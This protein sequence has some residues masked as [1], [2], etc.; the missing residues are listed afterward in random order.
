MQPH[1]L[2]HSVLMGEQG[3][4]NR[5][6]TPAWGIVQA[7]NIVRELT[8]ERNEAEDQIFT[9]RNRAISGTLDLRHRS[10]KVAVDIQDCQF[11]GEVDVRNC[12]FEQSVDLSRCTFHHAFNSGDASGASTVYKKDLVCSEATFEEEASFRGCRIESGATFEG[13]RFLG[14]EKSVDFRLA[15]V[16]DILRFTQAIFK[17]PAFFNGLKCN[18]I[19]LF[20]ET[21]F[22]SEKGDTPAVA[23]IDAYFSGLLAFDRATS[24]GGAYFGGLRCDFDGLLYGARFEGPA[25]FQSLECKNLFCGGTIFQREGDFRHATIGDSLICDDASFEGPANFS[26]LECKELSCRGT[27]FHGGAN[28]ESLKCS[29][30]G[31]FN[32]AEFQRKKPDSSD[33][34]TAADFRFSTFGGNLEC[35]RARF[36]GP[37]IF[38][39]GG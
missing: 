24:K 28:L 35:M 29:R 36:E 6:E 17:G 18:G 16:E 8:R 23:F 2:S 32:N 1:R 12:E 4:G 39:T 19:G 37:T 22:E 13:T 38:E 7:E 34:N 25:V 15:F 10:V 33:L 20:Q 9:L 26:G 3:L 21:K 5:T 11:R 31:F 14:T 30:G 27:T